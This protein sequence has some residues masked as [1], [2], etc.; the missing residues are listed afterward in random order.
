MIIYHP[1]WSNFWAFLN[2]WYKPLA[3]D[4]ERWDIWAS[5]WL[6]DN[7]HQV[8]SRNKVFDPDENSTKC[9]YLLCAGYSDCVDEHD[10]NKR[11][12]ANFRRQIVFIAMCL[13]TAQ[14]TDIIKSEA[15]NVAKQTL[16]RLDASL[17]AYFNPNLSQ[18]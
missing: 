17:E 8:L 13:F 5:R 6:S 16:D 10:D 9:N 12:R 2:K 18:K 11:I 1:P 7:S 15:A 4:H 3:D 14:K